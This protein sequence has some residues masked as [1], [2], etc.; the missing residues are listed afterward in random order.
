V[1][2]GQL[3]QRAGLPGLNGGGAAAAVPLI[4]DTYIASYSHQYLHAIIKQNILT[5]TSVNTVH[6]NY[7]T[8]TVHFVINT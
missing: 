5:H 2:R 1:T 3:P 4:H 7:Y 6:Y 8:Y